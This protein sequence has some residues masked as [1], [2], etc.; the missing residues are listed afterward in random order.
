MRGQKR[1]QAVFPGNAETT[2]LSCPGGRRIQLP[3]DSWIAQPLTTG[4]RCGGYAT[5]ASG[6]AIRRSATGK[7]LSASAFSPIKE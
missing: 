1:R 3:V 4:F 7:P 5:L 6:N 2:L